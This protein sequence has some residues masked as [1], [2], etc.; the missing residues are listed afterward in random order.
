MRRLFELAIVLAC[1]ASAPAFAQGHGGPPG[2]ANGPGMGRGGM[3]LGTPFVN[4]RGLPPAESAIHESATRSTGLL[5]V[6]AGRWWN[7]QHFIQ[8][9]GLKAEQQRRMDAIFAENRETLS[10]LYKNFM[11][12][13]TLLEK[14]AS[15]KNLDEEQIFQQIDRMNL[16]RAELEKANAHMQL[17]LRKGLTAEQASRLDDLRA[18]T[19][20]D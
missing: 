9:V 14:M 13:Q 19:P 8:T 11:H 15:G 6:P 10:R 7:D 2:G 1:L 16:A 12:E 5:F 17:E 4:D 3:A 20:Q 18:P